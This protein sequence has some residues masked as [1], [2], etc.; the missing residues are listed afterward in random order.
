MHSQIFNF[1]LSIK[2]AVV[3]EFQHVNTYLVLN[4]QLISQKLLEFLNFNRVQTLT[5]EFL[6]NQFFDL[7]FSFNLSEICGENYLF[8][9]EFSS[10][11]NF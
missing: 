6:H 3:L 5:L 7:K 2:M 4:F 10:K 11:R 9:S 1:E 8:F